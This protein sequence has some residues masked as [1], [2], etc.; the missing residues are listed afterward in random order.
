[1]GIDRSGTRQNRTAC[2]PV[3]AAVALTRQIANS[4]RTPYVSSFFPDSPTAKEKEQLWSS[5]QKT[6]GDSGA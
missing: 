6:K 3:D 2:C 1:M 4:R 5:L